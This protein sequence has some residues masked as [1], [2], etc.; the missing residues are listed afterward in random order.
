MEI[1]EE[2]TMKHYLKL[3]TALLLCIMVITTM[4]ACGSSGSTTIQTAAPTTGTTQSAGTA[5]TTTAPMTID[6]VTFYMRSFN[7]VEW[8]GSKFDKMVQERFGLK[9]DLQIVD[10]TSYAEKYKILFN[11]GTLPDISTIGVSIPEV[12]AAGD[13][14][15]LLDFYNYINI[16]PNLKKI[17]TD[18]KGL[19]P[20]IT[21]ATGSLYYSPLYFN[22]GEVVGSKVFA[23]R[24]DLLDK[25]GFDYKSIKDLDGVY[26]L[27]T[28]L[29]KQDPSKYV[30]G[31]QYGMSNLYFQGMTMGANW[32][33]GLWDNNK[34][35]WIANYKQDNLKEFVTFW[36]KAYADGILHP[37]FLTMQRTDYWQKYFNGELSAWVDDGNNLDICMENAAAKEYK[38][39]H[40]VLPEYKGKRYGITSS[41]GLSSSQ[42]R[43]V[44]AKTKYP[45]KI[46]KFIDW[47]Y[48][49]ECFFMNWCGEE[50]VDY[51]KLSDEPMQWVTLSNAYAATLPAQYQ[52]KLLTPEKI[53]ERKI[54]LPY[55]LYGLYAK[56]SE[57]YSLG[58]YKSP[59][60]TSLYETAYKDYVKA[61]LY[62][63]P[64]PSMTLTGKELEEYNSLV[65]TIG[66][67]ANETIAKMVTGQ[68]D[69]SKGWDAFLQNIDKY[70]YTRL[71]E[72]FNISAKNFF[73]VK[74]KFNP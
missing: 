24:K 72:L 27:L 55:Y 10:T 21:S 2:R 20:Y 22:M 71:M 64:D 58:K 69:V 38:W 66:D 3:I 35:Q 23:A 74:P 26:A 39:T 45:E 47:C 4:M 46:M 41:A 51:I 5:A 48:S 56:S 53:A 28:A 57:W 60:I 33:P 52:S 11:A 42:G 68:T 59:E 16:M 14:G 18:N 8:E 1:G 17:L 73:S 70:G 40:I 62:A 32:G 50:G 67:Y 30:I 49:N 43:L 12:T 6:K 19:L 63:V 65:A 44:S 61:N 7:A 34:K 25:A 54:K 31:C 36:A 9:L 37:D 13:R 29:K 15:L